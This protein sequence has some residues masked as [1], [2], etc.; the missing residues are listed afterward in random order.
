M[1]D[2]ISGLSDSFDMQAPV[3]TN[4]DDDDFLNDLDNFESIGNHEVKKIPPLVK[5][6]KKE[7]KPASR[8]RLLVDKNLADLDHDDPYKV[9]SN[10]GG[11]DDFVGGQFYGQYPVADTDN[12]IPFS[13]GRSQRDQTIAH[14]NMQASI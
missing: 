9:R 3:D 12:T 8:P 14:S 5:E 10:N 11:N 7:A 6:Y 1:V 2:D 13:A 4:K